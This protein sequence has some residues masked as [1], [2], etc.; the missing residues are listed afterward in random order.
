M[1]VLMGANSRTYKFAL[2]RALL[3]AAGTGADFVTLDELGRT[4]AISWRGDRSAS[5]GFGV[6]NQFGFGLLGRSL[7]RGRCHSFGGRPDGPIGGRRGHLDARD[8][9]AEVTT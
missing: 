6:G 4:Y 3:D 1:A 2:A 9:D 5:A 7:P 8:G